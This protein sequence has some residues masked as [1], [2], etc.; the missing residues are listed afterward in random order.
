MAIVVESLRDFCSHGWCACNPR[1][2]WYNN[3]RPSQ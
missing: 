3:A 1:S 2:R